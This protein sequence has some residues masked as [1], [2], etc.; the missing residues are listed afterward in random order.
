MAPG[1]PPM[2]KQI[3]IGLIAGVFAL[4]S[5][6]L[7]P[8]EAQA[9]DNNRQLNQMAMQMYMQNMANQ[10]NLANQNLLAQQNYQNGFGNN[11]YNPYWNAN[12]NNWNN[13]NQFCGNNGN[14]RGNWQRRGNG[15]WNKK[16]KKAH[17]HHCNGNF[18]GNFNAANFNNG[19]FNQ[20]NNPL[21][22]RLNGIGLNNG[23]NNGLGFNNGFNGGVNQSAVG[24]VLN[25]FF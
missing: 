24:R 11:G 13:N 4:A 7:A 16:W 19:N 10:Q 8:T 17:H 25:R 1:A 22:N 6:V 2:R 12:N 18:N 3:A 14:N 21:L 23:F 15:N 9:K 20:F 5:G